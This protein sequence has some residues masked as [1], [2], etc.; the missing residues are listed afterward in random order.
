MAIVPLKEE[1]VTARYDEET[2]TVYITYNG[3]LGAEDSGAA[4]KWIDTVIHEVG[5][6]NVYG[7][8][9]DFR[10][11]YEFLPENLMDARKKSRRMN[12][13]NNIRNLPVAMIVNGLV[14]EEILRGPLQNVP[15]NTRKRIVYSMDEAKAFLDEWHEA[16]KST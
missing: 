13:K 9:F 2:N 10:E 4:Y 7:E 6:E 16:Q 8:I 12:M 5:I 14:Q 15:E 1:K 3:S 11:V